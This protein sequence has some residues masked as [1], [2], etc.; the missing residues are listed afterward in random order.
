MVLNHSKQQDNLKKNKYIQTQQ[1]IF[2]DMN[3]IKKHRHQHFTRRKK[4]RKTVTFKK[5]D[6]ETHEQKLGKI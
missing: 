6:I 4:P 3:K 2:D 1:S 5:K